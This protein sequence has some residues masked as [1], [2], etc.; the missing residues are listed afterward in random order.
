VGT[1][2]QLFSRSHALRGNADE[3]SDCLLYLQFALEVLF[4]PRQQAKK[5]L[6]KPDE[7]SVNNLKHLYSHAERGNEKITASL[8][9]S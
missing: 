7:K 9:E 8:K 2:H 6:S 5:G 1:A 3:N 4:R